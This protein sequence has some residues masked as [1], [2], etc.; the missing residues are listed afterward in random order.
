MR[1]P[2][3]LLFVLVPV[4]LLLG[5]GTVAFA[6]GALPFTDID[7]HWAEDAI[8]REYERGVV[9]GSADG[10]FRPDDSLTRAEMATML[11][12]QGWCP[13]CHN[14]GTELTGKSAAW[15]ESLHGTGTD[16]P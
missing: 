4:L 14:A 9:K 15:G 7:G 10:T 6:A 8:V 3:K 11:D 16:I 1:I 12:R 2:K 13:D 5:A